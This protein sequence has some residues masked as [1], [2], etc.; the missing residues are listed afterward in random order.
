MS[1]RPNIVWITLD[2]VRMDHTTMGGHTRDTTPN[3]SEL[4]ESGFSHDICI[5]PG[6]GTPYSSG[7]FLTGTYPFY[8]GLQFENEY[9]PKEL[10]TVPELLRHVGYST[11]GLSRNSF[12]GPGTGLD[13][14]FDRFEW[15]S[16]SQLFNIV[17]TS[18]LV[19]WALNIRQHS[20]GFSLDTGKH[21]TPFLMNGIAKRW[22]K[23]LADSEPFFLY[24]HYNEPHHPYY[25]P[26]SYLDE[27]T[28][29]IS[30]STKE[31]A[32]F[33]MEMHNKYRSWV[34]NNKVLTDDELEALQALYD[35]EI[36]Y[37]DEMI[38]RLTEYIQ[39]LGL[40]DTI[41]VITADHGDYFGEK[42]LLS[43]VLSIDDGI[44]HTPLVVHGFD[45]IRTD[46]PVIQQIDVMEALVATA[47]GETEQ[48]QGIDVRN[49]IREYAI[50]NRAPVDQETWR[51]YNSEFDASR[52]HSGK[53]TSIHT[54][55]FR[56]QSSNEKSELFR[57][58]DETQDVS[59]EFPN[60]ADYLDGELEQWLKE[61]GKPIK[62]EEPSELTDEMQQQLKNLGYIE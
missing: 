12:V 36:R 39:S 16:S 8:H 44:T 45:E 41:I 4:A 40:E 18:V 57:L 46:S 50:S 31:A 58:P 59:K 22:L 52:F 7:S 37:T 9:I 3:I 10:A 56:Y 6:Q 11:A 27:Y 32:S 55:E 26:L 42:N 15:I 51:E 62:E 48:F 21:S 13:R 17:P 14:G 53:L 35:A 24:L 34:A 1:N 19:K 23:D 25:P 28:D 30:F 20:A 54:G 5:A 29:D 47:G 60:V 33:A 43:H 38:G 2:S 61:F 49:E